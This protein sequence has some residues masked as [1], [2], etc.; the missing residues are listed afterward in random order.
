MN[1]PDNLNA[2]RNAAHQCAIQMMENATYISKELP[3]VDMPE[4]IKAKTQTMCASLIETKHDIITELFELEEEAKT[5][6]ASSDLIPHVDLIV[7]WLAETTREMCDVVDALREAGEKDER[8]ILGYMLLS[9]SAINV[10]NAFNP[11]ADAARAMKQ[12]TGTD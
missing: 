10:L 1:T 11:A 7:K 6:S 2:F 12:E 8:F 5:A 3:S 4:A 9:E